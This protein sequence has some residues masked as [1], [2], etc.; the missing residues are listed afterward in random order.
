MTN[1]SPISSCDRCPRLVAFGNVLLDIS[2]EL[3]GDSSILKDFDLKEDDQREIPAE[4]LA[5]LVSVAVE[6]CGT[7]K[8]NPG[9]SALNTCRILRALGEKNIIFCGAVGVDEYGIKLEQML[10]D[11]SL[12]TCIQTLP[13]H[14]TGTCI[15]LISGDK[16]SLNANI[17][18]SLHFKK[19]FV[20]SRWCQSKIGSCNSAAH[21]DVDEEVR[22]FY[23]EGYFVPEKFA[24]CKHIYEKYCKGT[25]NLFVTNLN[26]TYILQTYTKE[27]QYLIEQ[28][29]LVFGNLTEFI[30]LA[31]I[32]ECDDVDQLAKCLIRKYLKINREK[33]I[34]ATDASRCVR[35][36][37]GNGSSF[38]AETFQV[39]VIPSKA[40]I[41]TTGAGDSFVAGFLYKYMN[42]E[43]PTLT[44]C[45]RYASK[46]AGKVIRQVGCNLP[47][48]LPAS[49]MTQTTEEFESLN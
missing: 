49:P 10:S 7:P 47:S 33:I 46:V 21:A 13:E 24:I 18:A 39:P 3:R 30:A 5:R 36:Y 40:V 42:G 2:V 48:S 28:S 23:V 8:Y 32:Y 1:D 26:A 9:G 11:S 6:T 45:I 41:D 27:M 19:E 22:V 17:G 35:Y 38:H 20:S 15:C 25:A 29:D 4:K 43:A 34:V 37:H 12:N 44:D 31:E 16:R 14:P